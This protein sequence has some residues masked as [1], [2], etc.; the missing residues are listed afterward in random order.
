MEDNDKHLTAFFPTRM[1]VYQAADMI[2][3]K[4]NRTASRES[5]VHSPYFTNYVVGA[6][7]PN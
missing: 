7:A 6:G 4:S 1:H 2:A 5:F 3:P